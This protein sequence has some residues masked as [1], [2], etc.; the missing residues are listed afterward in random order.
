MTK[1]TPQRL[2]QL[3]REHT[4]IVMITAYDHPSALAAEAA[5]V[6][7]VLVGD[8]AAMTMLGYPSTTAVTVDELLVL[9]RAVRRGLSTPMLVGDL[10]FGS[11]QASDEQAVDTAVRFVK[12]AGCE[13]VKLEGGGPAACSRAAAI[14]QAG[15]AV[16]G[17]IG[18]TP[19]SAAAL[20]GFTAQGRTADRAEQLGAEAAALAA[21]GCCAIVFEAIP[22]EVTA[23]LMPRIDIP[24]IGI[25]AG[26]ATDG[27]VLV[28]HDLLGL[29][30]GPRARF[31][32]HYARLHEQIVDGLGRF[33]DDVRRHRYPAAEHNY[34]IPAAE[35]TELRRRLGEA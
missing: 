33:A 24:V 32:Q 35:L 26:P 30:E 12:Q 9:T 2:A 4:P 29:G 31:V 28:W 16:V 6:D 22:A 14:V 19:Q 11:Y 25:G 15:I 23:L 8:S 21:A 13:A 7:V 18:L 10:P 1:T 5:G 27:Q 17:H 3:K 20:G 34:R